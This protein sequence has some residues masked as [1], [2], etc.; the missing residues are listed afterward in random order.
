MHWYLQY[1]TRLTHRSKCLKFSSLKCDLVS[2][3]LQ[4]AAKFLEWLVCPH[5]FPLRCKEAILLSRLRQLLR[6]TFLGGFIEK[7]QE[8]KRKILVAESVILALL[9]QT[10][11]P[12]RFL[13]CNYQWKDDVQSF[14]FPALNPE[15]CPW[16]K[17]ECSP[18][19]ALYPFQWSRRQILVAKYQ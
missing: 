18:N 11:F 1:L 6:L 17:S 19:P 5:E 10:Y 16:F 2:K 9:K 3:T 7:H 13:S 14:D 8:N 15:S 4:V 12:R